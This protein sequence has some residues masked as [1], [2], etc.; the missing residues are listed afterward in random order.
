MLTCRSKTNLISNLMKRISTARKRR[1][2]HTDCTIVEMKNQKRRTQKYKLILSVISK[3]NDTYRQNAVYEGIQFGS[4]LCW[5]R[6]GCILARKAMIVKLWSKL[7]LPVSLVM[8]KCWNKGAT[9]N[10]VVATSR[11]DGD[12]SVWRI[13]N[14]AEQSGRRHLWV[15]TRHQRLLP[16]H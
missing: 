14:A 3:L 9:Q 8:L 15:F 6:S 11:L 2:W 1:W 12:I 10:C 13:G 7:L 5:T 16:L 4:V